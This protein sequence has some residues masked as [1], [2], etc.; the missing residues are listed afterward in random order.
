MYRE[1]GREV[2]SDSTHTH[3]RGQGRTGEFSA[4]AFIYICS[5]KYFANLEVRYHEKNKAT[6]KE[7][8]GR[9]G[10]CHA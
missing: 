8:R 6:K 10:H 1:A 4:R 2:S 9:F 5:R 7:Q 3:R